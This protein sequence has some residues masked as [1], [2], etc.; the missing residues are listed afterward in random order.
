MST[1]HDFSAPLLPAAL[2][3]AVRGEPVARRFSVDEYHRMIE[4][5]ILSEDD[6]VELLDGW[7]LE[8]SPIGP[9]HEVCISLLLEE[10]QQSLSSGWLVRLQSPITL[11]T[12]EPQPDVSVVRGRPRDYVAHHPKPD[13]VALVVEVADSSLTFDRQLKRP[14]YAA[15]GIPEYWIVNLIDRQL[16]IYRDLAAGGDYTKPVILSEADSVPLTIDGKV[17]GTLRVSDMLP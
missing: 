13:E 15:A 8:M 12:S 1:I 10:L 16:E 9:P 3:P 11:S 4:T 6:R 14:R 2:I 7:I 17:A 5:G